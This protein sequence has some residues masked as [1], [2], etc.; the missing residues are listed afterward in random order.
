LKALRHDFIVSSAWFQAVLTLVCYGQPAPPH[1]AR[2]GELREEVTHGG[3]TVHLLER[4]RAHL[5]DAAAQVEFES[6]L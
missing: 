4:H 5:L 1:L 6:K 2:R 3:G